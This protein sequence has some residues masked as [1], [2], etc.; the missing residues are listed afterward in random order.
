MKKSFQHVHPNLVWLLGSPIDIKFFSRVA[1]LHPRQPT[2][3]ATHGKLVPDA[4]RMPVCKA[5]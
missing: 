5:V 3:V 4:V 2:V 1:M